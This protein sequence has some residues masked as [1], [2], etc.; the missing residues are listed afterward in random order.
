MWQPSTC[1]DWPERW[2]HLASSGSSKDLEVKSDR[3]QEATRT[4]WKLCFLVLAA[5]LQLELK[6]LCKNTHDTQS[7]EY[8]CPPQNSP[9]LR[10]PSFPKSWHWMASVSLVRFLSWQMKWK[11]FNEFLLL[12]VVNKTQTWNQT[13]TLIMGHSTIKNKNEIKQILTSRYKVL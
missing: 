9:S 13:L 12:S 6:R 5:V 1:F 4:L 8:N 7:S 3:I 10:A 11:L 2:P